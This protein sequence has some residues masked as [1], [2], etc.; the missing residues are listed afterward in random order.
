MLVIY[1]S[2]LIAVCESGYVDLGV[3]NG[4]LLVDLLGYGGV[5]DTDLA[6]LG[7][8]AVDRIEVS[9]VL[10]GAVSRLLNELNGSVLDIVSDNSD[11]VTELTVDGFHTLGLGIEGDSELLL[12][13]AQT[14]LLH[15]VYHTTDFKET[16]IRGVCGIGLH[17]TKLGGNNG[18]A[19]GLDVGVG[20]VDQ[21]HIGLDIDSQC[22]ELIVVRPK[23]RVNLMEGESLYKNILDSVLIGLFL[24]RTDGIKG[25]VCCMNVEV[26]VT[27]NSCDFFNNICFDC[28]ILC[29]S[30]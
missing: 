24:S 9:G 30:V 7:L 29:S 27:V 19:E 10:V 8:A 21:L 14:V 17:L 22:L 13:V 4:S 1:E 15:A 16:E 28:N 3:Y 5:N 26:I 6:D 18:T 12:L 23:I 25:S 2:E 20:G 11:D